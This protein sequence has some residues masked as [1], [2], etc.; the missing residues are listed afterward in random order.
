MAQAEIE[1][2]GAPHQDEAVGERCRES[3]LVVAN[4]TLASDQVLQL[5]RVWR[6]RAPTVFTLLIPAGANGRTD[7]GA[8]ELS[9]A[10]AI[11]R[12]RGSGLEVERAIL[13]ASDPYSAV[14][15]EYDPSRYDQIV[16]STL[17]QA[18]SRWLRLDV[19]RRVQRATG[20]VV[21][22]VSGSGASRTFC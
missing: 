8:A 22:H 10:R 9:L 20:A 2:A 7:I 17:D 18:E 21:T 3:V 11:E 19:P 13:R 5:M 4:E 1:T 14:C 15:E 6:G 16:V 12:M